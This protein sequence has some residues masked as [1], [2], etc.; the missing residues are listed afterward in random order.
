MLQLTVKETRN[1]NQNTSFPRVLYRQ[2]M[3]LFQPGLFSF[4]NADR[5]QHRYK[6]DRIDMY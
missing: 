4:C 5:T 2:I 6:T 1:A 3:R